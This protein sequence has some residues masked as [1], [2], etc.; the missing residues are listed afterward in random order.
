MQE[1]AD[2]SFNEDA[3]YRF[4]PEETSAKSFFRPPQPQPLYPIDETEEFHD[5]FSDLSLFLSKKIKQEVEKHGSSKQWS[6]KIQNDLLARILPEFKIKFPKYRLGVASIKKVWEKVSYYYGKVHTHQEALDDQGKLNIQFMIQEN[7]R[8]YSPKN[9]PHLSPYHVAQQLA[10]KLCECVATLEGTKL[11]LDHLTRSIWAVQKHLIPSLPAQSCKNAADDFDALDKLIVKMLLETIA[12][13]PLTPQK[14]LQQTVKEKLYTLSTFLQ[15]TSIEELYQYLATF[16]S[17]HLYPNLS[18]HKNLSHE[19]KLILQE[20]IDGQLHLTKTKNKQEEVSLRI[21]TVQRILI[22]YLLSTSLPKDFS[23]KALQEA[24]TSVYYQKKSSSQMPQSVK[25]FI[26]A[27]LHFLKRK[28]KDVSYKAIESA[29]TSTFLTVQ[30]LPR[31][32]EDYLEELEILSWKS[33]QKTIPSLQKK[34]TSFLQEELAHSLLD[35]PHYS[36]KDTLYHTLNAFK[37]HKTLL[38]KNTLEEQTL[39]W[40]ELDHKIYTWSIQ[41]TMLCRWMH[42]NHNTPLFT[43]LIPYWES[44]TP[45]DNLNKSLEYFLFKNPSPSL[46]TDHLRQRIAILYYHFWYHHVGEPQDTSLESFLRWHIQDICSHHPKKSK[47]EHLCIL[48][49]RCH[50]LLPATPISRKHLEVLMSGRR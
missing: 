44:S 28:E 29:I 49:N 18:L 48:E 40:E 47:D 43:T 37:T 36:F 21:E 6:N 3:P 16:L 8:G 39:L 23:L 10:V 5:P 45:Q 4:S 34:E 13:A 17:T 33:L 50:T 2:S 26:Q 24:I 22:L 1:T 46:S 7:L 32:K 11:R 27:E 25:T 30:K 19:E 9:S 15:K 14:I 35:Y 31:W 20:F 41:N 38:S 12:T 42:F